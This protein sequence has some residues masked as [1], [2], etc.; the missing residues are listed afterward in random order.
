MSEEFIQYG[1]ASVAGFGAAGPGAQMHPNPCRGDRGGYHSQNLPVI[2]QL[3]PNRA[4]STIGYNGA[5]PGPVLRMR[6]GKPV[7]VDVVNETDV[8][9]LVHWHGLFI[10]GC[11]G[12]EEEGTPMVRPMAP[13]VPVCAAA[14]GNALVSHPY[15]GRHDLHRGTY[16][17]QFGFVF[18]ESANNPG[19]Y[20]QEVFLLCANGT[21]PDLGRY[22]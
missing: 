3:D 4:I 14:R 13:P 12:S 22:G 16:T 1:C 17:G 19:R 15:D 18:I 9:E 8:P 10:R 5:S 6:E 11:D 7:T 20:D 21:V 2:V